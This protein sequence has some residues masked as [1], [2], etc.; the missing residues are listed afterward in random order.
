MSALVLYQRSGCQLC[1]DMRRE[2]EQ[3][4]SQRG[5]SLDLVDVDTSPELRSRYGHL[6]PVLEDAQGGEICHFFLELEPLQ[7]YLERG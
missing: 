6:V 7:R 4:R 5:F 2:L 3:L 1:E